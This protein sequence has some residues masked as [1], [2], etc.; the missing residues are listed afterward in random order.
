[1][2]TVLSDAVESDTLRAAQNV[3]RVNARV[4]D[5][6]HV[7]PQPLCGPT[8][9]RANRGS[10][11]VAQLDLLKMASL[12]V[13]VPHMDRLH[14]LLG[15]GTEVRF[16]VDPTPAGILFGEHVFHR[17]R[18]CAKVADPNEKSR[19]VTKDEVHGT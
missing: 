16:G 8:G 11:L 2:D 14:P 13:V 5:R 6:L 3:G 4:I 12:M 10:I 15:L 1:M 18:T 19:Q 17:P 9:A 7:E